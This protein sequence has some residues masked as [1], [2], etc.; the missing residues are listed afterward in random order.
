MSA[1]TTA[2][3]A[4][5]SGL[6][7]YDWEEWYGLNT[8]VKSA[9]DLPKGYSPDSL[10]WLPGWNNDIQKSDHIALR[11][12]MAILG[13]RS[14]ASGQVS[15][16]GVGIQANGS[17][18]PVWTNGANIYY[19]NAANGQNV[20]ILALPAAAASDW[21]SI[22][23]LSSIAGNYVE[24]SSYNSSMYRVPVATPTGIVDV[25]AGQSPAGTVKGFLNFVNSRMNLWNKNG[26]LLTSRNPNDYFLSQ[27]DFQTYAPSNSQAS[28]SATA[29]AVYPENGA[30]ETVGTGDG[31]TKTF[32]STLAHMAGGTVSTLLAA[33]ATG[34]PGIS[35]TGITAANPAVL[36]VTGSTAGLAV[37]QYIV[38]EGV[39]GSMGTNIND[40]I[41]QITALTGTTITVQCDTSGTSYSSGGTVY[42]V[43]YFTD[44]GNGNMVSNAGG[45]GTI[46]YGTGALVLNFFTAPINATNIGIQYYVWTPLTGVENF[47]ANANIGAATAYL[48]PQRDGGGP[49]QTVQPFAGS[50]FCFHTNRT[51]VETTDPSTVTNSSNIPYRNN[52]GAAFYKAAAATGDGIIFMDLSVPS[53]PRFQ[54][55]AIAPNTSATTIEPFN[56]GLDIDFS[57]YAFSF[58]VVFEFD[59]YYMIACQ[60]FVNGIP[61]IF[62]DTVYLQ[63]K[64]SNYW[65]KL[66]YEVSQL[67]QYNGTCIGGSSVSPN[68]FTLFSGFDDDG[69]YINNY[70]TSPVLDL[71]FPGL[72]TT[73]RFV[74]EGLIQSAQTIEIYVSY[75]EGEFTLVQTINGTDPC[76]SQGNPQLVGNN[77]TGSQSVGAGAVYANPFLLDFRLASPYYQYIQVKFVATGIGY[78]EVDRWHLK[79]NQRKSLAL[80][81]ANTL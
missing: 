57:L 52:I 53:D 11:G 65:S 78:I 8:M 5:G 20:S 77:T 32:S 72:K 38:V 15:G 60:S 13:N 22:E 51:W 71:D 37:G 70:W 14:V 47:A 55:L 2:R 80:N 74:I 27:I 7:D 79:V 28:V 76:V 9:K 19:Y 66:D 36:T 40:A 39:S 68:V 45:T 1:K 49:L 34:N 75:D 56:L 42:T 33:G 58:S 54:L 30:A 17:Q 4:S 24:I 67:A 69:S 81:P 6:P 64:R 63:D 73:N 21:F 41:L 29:L 44:D 35:I 43:E 31:A 59:F 26:S 50:N 23:P 18:V 10:N 25:N 46:N 3:K 16:L 61:R 48:W 12:G 62:N